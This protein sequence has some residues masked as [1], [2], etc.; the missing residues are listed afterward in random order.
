VFFALGMLTADD[1]AAL[2]EGSDDS[3]DGSGDGSGDDVTGGA[4][5]REEVMAQI[6]AA[7]KAAAVRLQERRAEERRQRKQR[8]SNKSGSG[9]CSGSGSSSDGAGGGN[10]DG[11]DSGPPLGAGSTRSG[12][13][14]GGV[15]ITTAWRALPPLPAP[16]SVEECCG[17][18]NEASAGLLQIAADQG[19][20]G[21]MVSAGEAGSA[22]AA[23][24]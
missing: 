6:K 3:S 20:A 13:G 1:A 4:A 24:F 16:A 5:N 14:P 10:S 11:G 2:T 7:R 8:P 12:V 9:S 22:L 17:E 15:T 21:A 18:E 23:G 19:H